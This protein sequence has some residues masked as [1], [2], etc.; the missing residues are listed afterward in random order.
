MFTKEAKRVKF[1]C[2]TFF[3]VVTP[4]VK[5]KTSIKKVLWICNYKIEVISK[6]KQPK[7][8][9]PP[10][11]QGDKRCEN[12]GGSQEMTVIIVPWQKL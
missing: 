8:V 5:K 9:W 2:N 4:V 12:K 11:S 7:T 1:E 6:Q 3:I 10:K